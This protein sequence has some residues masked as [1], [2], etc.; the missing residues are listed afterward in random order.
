MHS[1]V[2]PS[3][4]EKKCLQCQAK[5]PLQ[6]PR[7]SSA[8]AAAAAKRNEIDTE[9]IRVSTSR[10]LVRLGT[11]GSEGLGSAARLAFCLQGGN[12]FDVPD[13][14]AGHPRSRNRVRETST[15]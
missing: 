15:S 14:N 7:P 5:T 11:T 10:D 2:S 13:Q 12:M 4:P 6:N 9:Q 1:N 8:V 3:P